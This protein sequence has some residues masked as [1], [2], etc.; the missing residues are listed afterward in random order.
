MKRETKGTMSYEERRRFAVGVLK[1]I[2]APVTPGNVEFLL[3]WMSRE[4]T[5]AKNNPLATTFPSD[6][7]TAFNYQKKDGK[8]VLDENGDKIPLVK[9]YP[10]FND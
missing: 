6:G 7:W 3:A 4:N 9:N 10:S 2:A 8:F 5:A 1:G